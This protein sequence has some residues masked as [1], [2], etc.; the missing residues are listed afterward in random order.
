MAK[1][2]LC[3]SPHRTAM[4]RLTKINQLHLVYAQHPVTETAVNPSRA[5]DIP[6]DNSDFT[7]Q[8]FNEISEETLGCS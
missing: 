7:H 2:L 3:R 1:V 8:D 4:I 5:A 6:D